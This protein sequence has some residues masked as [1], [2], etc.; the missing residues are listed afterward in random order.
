MQ[1]RET[2]QDLLD[3]L[4]ANNQL[5]QAQANALSTAPRLALTT[6]E[7]VS[8]LAGLIITVGLVW[9]ISLAFQDASESTV[10]IA[11]YLVAAIAAYASRKCATKVGVLQQLSEV[12][13]ICGVGAAMGATALALDL[14]NVRGEWIA[15]LIAV[16]VILWGVLRISNTQ[17]AGTV[18]IS[19]GV[20]AFAL[21][22]GALIDS[23]DFVIG[24][25]LLLIA[26]AVL[27]FLG[28]REINAAQLA[29]AVGSFVVIIGSLTVRTQFDAGYL[30][31]ICTGALLFVYGS[32]LLTPEML[33]AG[34]FCVITG[35]VLTVIRWVPNEMAQ[36]LVIIAAGVAILIVL[37][38]Q[39]KRTASRQSP[40]IPTA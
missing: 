36:G 8:Y 19:A 21:S 6:R 28:T 37:T 33:L 5:S 14:A 32:R 30:L 26:G 39:M 15:I 18:F 4:V 2:H 17:L 7:L 13:E 25:L 10:S 40:G 24:Q 34:T 9:V 11:L 29:R 38:A 31:P 1:K 27:V 3:D 12:L 22:V 23:N 16:L 20:P 35:I